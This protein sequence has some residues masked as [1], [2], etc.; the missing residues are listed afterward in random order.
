MIFQSQ[1]MK[2]PINQS[3][4]ERFK[5]VAR[6]LGCDEDEAA[7]AA[8]KKHE[9]GLAV[10]RNKKYRENQSVKA[11][12]VDALEKKLKASEARVLELEAEKAYLKPLSDDEEPRD[13]P[14]APGYA[15]EGEAPMDAE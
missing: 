13:Q 7:A 9:S 6:K 5:D 1:P 14:G 15:G 3:Q 12:A 2:Q 11:A 10:A 4:I 8:K